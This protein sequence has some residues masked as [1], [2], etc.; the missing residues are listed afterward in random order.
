MRTNTSM[1]ILTMSLRHVHC[2]DT[3]TG[4]ESHARPLAPTLQTTGVRMGL[5]AQPSPQAGQAEKPRGKPVSEW[6]PSLAQQEVKR[7]KVDTDH[8]QRAIWSYRS[9]TQDQ[10]V[11]VPSK[12]A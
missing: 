11:W 7:R 3:H 8:F 5:L 12:R 6:M 9:T 2:G 10:A 1:E 4:T